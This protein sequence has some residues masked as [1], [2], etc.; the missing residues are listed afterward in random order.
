MSALPLEGETW[1]DSI[2]IPG[3]AS[4]STHLANWRWVSPGYFET[5]QQSLIAGRPFEERDRNLNTVILS[6]SA[7][8]AVFGSQSGLG[9]QIQHNGKP[10][11][12]VGIARDARS[13]SLKKAPPYMVYVHYKDNP[14]LD[15]AFLVRSTLP[16]DQI[17]TRL[18]EAI[19]Q[20]DPAVTIA[21]IK[22]LE[23]QVDDSLAPERFQAVVLIGFGLSALLLAMVGIYAVL[24]LFGR[25]PETGDRPPHCS[26]AAH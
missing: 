3:H 6:Q 10:F 19:W 25:H 4:Q 14:P 16:I 17:A 2:D 11:T 20:R 24:S 26:S 23:S 7:A 13:T 5:M 8:R 12:V 1:L 18:R 21:R 22:T 9:R 15:P